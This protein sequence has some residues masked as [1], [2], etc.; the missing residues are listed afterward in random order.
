MFPALALSN[1]SSTY[2]RA[3]EK[4]V[5]AVI[6]AGA[7]HVAFRNPVQ[8]AAGE[9]LCTDVALLGPD[10]A[11]TVLAICSGTHG[12]EGFCG[13]AIQ[14]GL[15]LDGIADRLPAGVRVVMIHGLNPYGFSHLRR[16]NEDN[17]DL[18]RNFF[19]HRQPHPANTAYDALHGAINPRADARLQRDLALLRLLL[20]RALKG[21]RALKVAITQGQHSHPTGLFFGGTCETWSNQTL[22]TIVGRF[23]KGAE[24]VAFIDIHSGLGP[25]GNGELI[26][27]FPPNSPTYRRMAAWWGDRVVPAEVS[28]VATARLTGTVSLGVSRMLAGAEVTPVALE[29]GT[30][31]PIKVLRALQA[32]NWLHHK[33]GPNHPDAQGIKTDLLRAFYPDSDAWRAAVWRQGKGVIDAALRGL[34]EGAISHRIVRA[35]G[36]ACTQSARPELIA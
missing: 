7:E 29:F 23:L 30:V 14:T 35:S 31:G 16:F 5:A 3:R 13:S 9:E 8:G 33:G 36:L 4:F 1:F 2:A 15:L 17:V 20:Q 26:C 19:D 6:A 25:F 24:R 18:N 27:R 12:V 11:R 21:K 10:S 34:S 22:R 32:E 28:T